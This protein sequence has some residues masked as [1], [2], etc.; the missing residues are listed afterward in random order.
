MQK[1]PLVAMQKSPPLLVVSSRSVNPWTVTVITGRDGGPALARVQLKVS[2]VAAR[3]L[4]TEQFS[5]DWIARIVL[6]AV[7]EAAAFV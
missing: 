3:K 2:G 5:R 6:D 4:A 7:E 1:S